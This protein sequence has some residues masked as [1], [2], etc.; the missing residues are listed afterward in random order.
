[1]E[2]TGNSVSIVLISVVL[3][4]IIFWLRGTNKE[5]EKYNEN[6][7]KEFKKRFEEHVPMLKAKGY[8][9]EKIQQMY[10]LLKKKVEYDALTPEQKDINKMVED[11]MGFLNNKFK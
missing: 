3:L 9:D 7:E 2:V 1:M 6:Y 5:I 11:P 10:Q 4:V 8:S